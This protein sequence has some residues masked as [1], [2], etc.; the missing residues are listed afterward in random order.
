[1][2]SLEEDLMKVLFFGVASLCV[3]LLSTVE[4][5]AMDSVTS[6]EFFVEPPT[7]LCAGFGR[8]GCGLCFAE[9]K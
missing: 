9:P 3:A 5:E 7:L 2:I 6:G 1:V 4:S 8:G